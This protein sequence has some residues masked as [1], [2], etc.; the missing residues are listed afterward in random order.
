MKDLFRHTEKSC[1][2]LEY[3]HACQTPLT[4]E[5]QLCGLIGM[6]SH[7]DVQ[8]SWI[9]GFFFENRPHWQ[10]EVEKISS[11]SCFRLHIYLCMNNV[12]IHNSLHVFDMGGGGGR[13]SA[14]KRC[15]VITVRQ[16]LSEGPS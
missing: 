6:A 15:S 10:F 1:S 3:S 11:N 7:L 12:L 14:K 8:E 9:I 5:L 2:R 13:T 16:C 4:V